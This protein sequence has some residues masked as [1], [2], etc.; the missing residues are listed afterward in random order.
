MALLPFEECGIVALFG[1]GNAKPIRAPVFLE[2][3]CGEHQ[4]LE[5]TLVVSQN[6]THLARAVPDEDSLDVDRR[7][8]QSAAG[9]TS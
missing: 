9:A 1:L 2:V 7:I 8:D 4:R 5:T 6:T 3:C